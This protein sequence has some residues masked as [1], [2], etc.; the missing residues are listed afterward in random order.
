IPV[1]AD[2]VE[3]LAK[4]RP[5]LVIVASPPALHAAHC[6]AAMNA[7]AD[8]LCEKPFTASVREGRDVLARAAAAG[9]PIAV[10]HEFRTMR[11]IGDATACASVTGRRPSVH[12]V[13]Q[14]TDHAPAGER[15][16]RGQLK[17]RGLYEAGVHLVDLAVQLFG[18]MPLAVSATFAGGD[19]GESAA[20]AI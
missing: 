18:E 5:D 13:G 20:D 15:G 12:Q 19:D 11:V 4:P 10:N 3:L 14:A 8:V 9:R 1:F 7:G 6:I 2:V 17:R 16:W